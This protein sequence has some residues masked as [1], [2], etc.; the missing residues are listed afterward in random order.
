VHD[1]AL[2]WIDD[3]SDRELDAALDAATDRELEELIR[4][5]QQVKAE[6]LAAGE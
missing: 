5:A 6:E 4:L 1:N 2:D 3:M